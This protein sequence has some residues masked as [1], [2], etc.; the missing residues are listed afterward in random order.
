MNATRNYFETLNWALI[1]WNGWLRNGDK[2]LEE[3][4]SLYLHEQLD[5]ESRKVQ[6]LDPHDIE[7][8][9]LQ[10]LDSPLRLKQL[11]DLGIRQLSDEVD[12]L[13]GRTANLGDDTINVRLTELQKLIIIKEV[14][15]EHAIRVCESYALP[16]K[17]TPKKKEPNFDDCI[18]Y[19]DKEKL[20]KRLHELIDG[21]SGA[22]VGSVLFRAKYVE[23][24]LSRWPTQAE[25]K[26]EFELI[27]T[28]S[29]IHNYFDENSAK[30][31]DRAANVIIFQ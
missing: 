15:L 24:Y 9:I 3:K 13:A 21:K 17:K 27:G 11:D 10:S 31:H 29:A 19:G 16:K 22:D 1:S 4:G 30:A 18:Q 6:E 5:I 14:E 26:Q 8:D 7:D 20:K 12:K 25:F 2:I 28:W 23:G